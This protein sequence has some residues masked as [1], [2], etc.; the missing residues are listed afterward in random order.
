[1]YLAANSEEAAAKGVHENDLGVFTST[2]SVRFDSEDEV[3]GGVIDG[4]AIAVEEK[5]SLVNCKL[6]FFI[7]N[8]AVVHRNSTFLHGNISEQ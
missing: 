4:E 8:K 6:S 7:V 5:T 1:M 2:D 3:A